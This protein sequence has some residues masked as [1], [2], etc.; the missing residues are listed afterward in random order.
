MSSDEYEASDEKEVQYFRRKA[1]RHACKRLTADELH[2]A[3]KR[4][5]ILGTVANVEQIN[6]GSLQLVM[7][8]LNVHDLL[9]CRRVC[10]TWRAA[11]D[12]PNLWCRSVFRFNSVE[13]FMRMVV[14]IKDK[15]FCRQEF[16][17]AI[18]S[19]H[20]VSITDMYSDRGSKYRKILYND[21]ESVVLPSPWMDNIRNVQIKIGCANNVPTSQQ[22]EVTKF[23]KLVFGKLLS[24][25][26][27]A[28]NVCVNSRYCIPALTTLQIM[29]GQNLRCVDLGHLCNSDPL[30][31]AHVPY[32]DMFIVA[33]ANNGIMLEALSLPTMRLSDSTMRILTIL[34]NR[35]S[36]S[37]KLLSLEIAS[38]SE[39]TLPA[40]SQMW[41]DNTTQAI[42]TPLQ[43][44][45]I[46]S[47]SIRGSIDTLAMYPFT[48]YT[49]L[50]RSVEQL[51]LMVSSTDKTNQNV[52]EFLRHF[53]NLRRLTVVQKDMSAR[54]VSLMPCAEHRIQKPIIT[55]SLVL[56]GLIG[57]HLQ[58]VQLAADTYAIDIVRF[59]AAIGKCAMRLRAL[60]ISNGEIDDTVMDSIATSF[61]HRLTF[62]YLGNGQNKCASMHG[63]NKV[64][65][66]FDPTTNP[67]LTMDMC[68][69]ER[70][71]RV[72]GSASSNT[73]P[74][75][76]HRLKQSVSRLR[77]L[78]LVVCPTPTMTIEQMST[79]E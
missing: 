1:K 68:F 79:N 17:D 18:S 8:H 29:A 50:G 38:P 36:S 31:A 5:K 64:I 32:L 9:S 54:D 2:I 66:C 69:F 30:K 76:Q 60:H 37:L 61:S 57:Q 45:A 13:S 78:C 63:M 58:I 67:S 51:H 12:T 4:P 21:L 42:G 74:E 75:R 71:T 27:H 41:I 48:N 33:L 62:L 19:C 16:V 35:C 26:T 46:K 23:D 25:F 14:E 40:D 7:S 15:S 11:V 59:I 10:T 52:P 77:D 72:P 28:T 53:T 73:V 20:I 56:D 24:G 34:V 39:L 43:P 22:N 49:D 6:V 47:L 65:D 55:F 44:L 3:A 70:V